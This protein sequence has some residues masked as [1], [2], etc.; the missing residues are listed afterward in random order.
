MA[1]SSPVTGVGVSSFRKASRSSRSLSVKILEPSAA[2][3]LVVSP[4]GVVVGFSVRASSIA[5][6]NSASSWAVVVVSPVEGFKVSEVMPLGARAIAPLSVGGGVAIV[7]SSGAGVGFS[8]VG[9]VL[10]SGVGGVRFSGVTFSGAG[11]VTFS[12]VGGVT[13]SG[14]GG[15]TFSGAG[16]VTF[17]GAGGVTLSGAGGVTFSGADGVTFSGAG[18]ITFSGA[19]GVTV[20]PVLVSTGVSAGASAGASVGIPVLSATK[21]SIAETS[22]EVLI[23]SGSL[24]ATTSG[25]VSVKALVSPLPKSNDWSLPPTSKES[26]ES[27]GSPPPPKSKS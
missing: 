19:G 24:N 17:S 2:G 21:S 10:L 9:G 4:V 26:K 6:K 13:F 14:A 22:V 18:G 7:F 23:G 25:V 16:G 20:S 1:A 8:A 12:G 27:E 11:G 15:T 3:V 5:S